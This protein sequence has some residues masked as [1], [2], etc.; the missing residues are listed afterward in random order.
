MERRLQLYGTAGCHL[1]D[2]AEIML[3]RLL[4][5]SSYLLEWTPVDVAEDDQ[6]MERYGITIPVILRLDTGV[7]L[8]W[9]FCEQDIELLLK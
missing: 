9:P 5:R 3:T 7:E 6:L 2:E 1:C 8:A 4:Q